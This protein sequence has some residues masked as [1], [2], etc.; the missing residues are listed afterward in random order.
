MEAQEVKKKKVSWWRIVGMALVI[1]FLFHW[2]F[3]SP[4][5]EEYYEQMDKW[6]EKQQ[7]VKEECR[8]SAMQNL[9]DPSITTRAGWDQVY[10]EQF[11]HCND[12]REEAFEMLEEIDPPDDELIKDTH[13]RL[14]DVERRIL[15]EFLGRED[16]PLNETSSEAIS[17]FNDRMNQLET[18]QAE[19]FSDYWDV[20]YV[21]LGDE[22]RD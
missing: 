16:I 14:V 2:A 1:F 19:V 21:K 3:G 18:E 10:L 20:R 22:D 13:E 6:T 17:M 11:K 5:I 8:K 12:M 7:E 15:Q 9:L 4:S